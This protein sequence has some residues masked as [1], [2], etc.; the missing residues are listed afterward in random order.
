MQT[1]SR[2]SSWRNDGLF[3]ILTDS[4]V[5]PTVCALHCADSLQA[6][7]HKV[8]TPTGRYAN[9]KEFLE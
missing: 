7:G 5:I 6:E 9:A 3:D 8:F 1:K 4:C 2:W